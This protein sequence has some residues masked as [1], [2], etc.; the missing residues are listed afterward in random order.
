MIAQTFRLIAAGAISLLFAMTSAQLSY[1]G[2][3]EVASFVAATGLAIVLI[4]FSAHGVAMNK[5]GRFHSRAGIFFIV[6][7]I[8]S[9]GMLAYTL[10][11]VILR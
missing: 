2:A 3:D 6:C 1:N 9:A 11:S 4:V 10:S 8:F 5:A 7:G